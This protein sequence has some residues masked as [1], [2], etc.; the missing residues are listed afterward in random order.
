MLVGDDPASAIYIRNKHK[1]ADEVGI[2]AIDKRL[3][4]STP[5]DEL[6]ELVRELNEDDGVDGILVQTPLPRAHRRRRA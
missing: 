3:P 2:E 1:A 6:V 4:A 5:E